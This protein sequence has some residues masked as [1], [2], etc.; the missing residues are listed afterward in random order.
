[1]NKNSNYPKIPLP[2]NNGLVE[3][4]NLDKLDN[5][6]LLTYFNKYGVVVFED[7]LNT[8][9]IKLTIDD[10]WKDFNH[11]LKNY[12]ENIQVS[13]EHCDD[14]SLA[15]YTNKYGF[16]NTGPV[17]QLQCWKN[18]QNP[19]VYKAFK[20]LYELTSKHEKEPL[21]A[22]LDRRSILRPGLKNKEWLTQDIYHFDINPWVFSDVLSETN[23]NLTNRVINYDSVDNLTNMLSE[24]NDG[25]YNGYPKLSGILVSSD[26]DSDSGG[27]EC[28]VGFQ[29]NLRDW[30]EKHEYGYNI[31]N[32]IGITNNMQKIYAKKGSLII[33]TRELPH[34]VYQNKSKNPRYAQ[35]VR[36][37][38]LS[39]LHL[40]DESLIKRKRLIKNLLPK[41]LKIDKIGKELFM[42]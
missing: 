23:D 5:Q 12:D 36:I 33:F 9:E 26:T 31:A 16:I 7:V 19:K 37:S 39:E 34:N 29:H 40:T 21:V 4:F 2:Y 15:N 8:N 14:M 6:K 41:D 18:R 30:C 35:Y 3:T 42:L 11:Y 17:N 38:P 24:G 22:C 25:K 32:D 27:F 10:L 28:F 13:E 1:M 20:T